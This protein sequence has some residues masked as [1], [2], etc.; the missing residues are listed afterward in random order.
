MKIRI[1]KKAGLGL[2]IGI[3][4][5]I[6]CSVWTPC[7]ASTENLK[8][9]V[10]PI[11]P[12]YQ[13]Y[14]QSIQSVTEH[15]TGF[16]PPSIDLSHLKG[17]RLISSNTENSYPSRYDL[18]TLSKMTQVK[19][20]NPWGTCWAFASIASLESSLKPEVSAD[21][22][23]KNMVNRNLWL[24]GPNTGGDYLT[25]GGYL[26]AGLGPVNET[27]DP[28]P[29]GT[30][31]YSSPAGPV[32]Y[33]LKE[34]LWIPGRE[35]STDLGT[36]KWAIQNY[37]AMDSSFYWDDNAWNASSNGYYYSSGNS[38]N[39][40]IV[41][42]GWDDSYSRFNFTTTAPGNGA[43]LFK[44]SWGTSWGDQGYGWISYYDTSLGKYNAE[45]I[46][47]NTAEYNGI[48]QYDPAGV[49]ANFGNSPSLDIWGGNVFTA[50]TNGTLSS[51]GFYTTDIPTSYVVRVYNNLTSTG[52]VGSQILSQKVG[53]IAMSGFH[54]IPLTT[55][56]S[57]TTGEK[58]SIVLHLNNTAYE[59]PLAMEYPPYGPTGN[60]WNA[61]PGQGYISSNSVNW[62]DITTELSN[63]SICIKGYYTGVTP[64]PTPTSTPTTT[65]TGTP[66]STPTIT[67]TSTPTVTPTVTPTSTPTVTPTSTPT[68]TPTVTP[69]QKYTINA[70]SD[71][72]G[73]I[74][75]SGL[76][77]VDAGK[78]VTF[79]FQARPGAVIANITVDGVMGQVETGDQYTFPSVTTNHTI[80]LACSIKAKSII[81]GL[82]ANVTSG[83]TPLTVQFND[84]TL[85]N[86][87]RW[88]WTFGDGGW[89]GD[90]NPIHTYSK[91]GIWTVRLWARNSWSSGIST[92]KG[93]I[94]SI[95]AGSTVTSITTEVSDQ[96]VYLQNITES[97]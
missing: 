75:P 17:T 93:L 50:S 73:Y 91:A 60:T 83:Q 66:T 62:T 12:D 46:G 27:T 48:Y 86:P 39:H 6:I 37:G 42:A 28:Y 31:N 2:C 81:A 34:I 43:F 89:S 54:I 24:T 80:S 9:G 15:P 36:I 92:K 77:S 94:R 67:P 78:N 45:F 87:T 57:I 55:P 59:Y 19:D 71:Q 26:A 1:I 51:V 8:P 18:R 14:N 4:F 22:S 63:T 29:N 53:T 44:N 13:V 85:G 58:F 70:T 90:Q 96:E 97:T 11:N 82:T 25:S 41:L 35:N 47:S 68:T 32:S 74:N 7:L 76:V 88:Y 30:W 16:V 49:S 79:R 23:E 40:E 69:G 61:S 64:S 52:P 20:Q 10:A 72:L 5:L 65:P 56:V 21:F 33:P 38:T 84:N 95:P 3:L